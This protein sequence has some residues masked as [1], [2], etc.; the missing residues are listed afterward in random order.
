MPSLMLVL[1]ARNRRRY[2]I[3]SDGVITFLF[4]LGPPGNLKKYKK[5]E[6]YY[7]SDS[8]S[9]CMISN[10]SRQISSSSIISISR[11]ILPEIVLYASFS[12]ALLILY[13]DNNQSKYSV[14]H[15]LYNV[16]LCY[17]ILI[18]FIFFIECIPVL[19]RLVSRTS[20]QPEEVQREGDLLCFL[21]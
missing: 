17:Y 20:W 1:S 7:A 15:F 12:F 8:S 10:S 11:R 16:T 3:S 13:N 9:R 5:K 14:V 21:L 18:V 4:L 6:N 19:M 2:F